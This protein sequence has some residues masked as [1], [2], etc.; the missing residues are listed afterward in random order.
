MGSLSGLGIASGITI[1][2]ALHEAGFDKE[3]GLKWPNDIV[4]K[5]HKLGGLII[6]VRGEHHGPC[7]VVLGI[8]L[9]LSLSAEEKQAIN[10]PSVALEEIESRSVD[11]NR[12]ASVLIRA[13]YELFEKYH[14]EDFETWRDQWARYDRMLGRE[15]QVIQGE[16]VRQGRAMGIDSQGALLLDAGEAEFSRFFSG[17]VSLR[18]GQ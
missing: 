16:T 4:W 5:D 14:Q 12:V 9:N 8:G 10:Q 3:I 2:R 15:V 6:D 18:L 13:L 1:A 11:R 17:D 7:Q